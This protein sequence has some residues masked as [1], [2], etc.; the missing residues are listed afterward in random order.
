M[1]VIDHN[2]ASRANPVTRAQYVTVALLLCLM[3]F[4]ALASAKSF[5]QVGT[6]GGVLKAGEVSEQNQLGGASALA[7]NYTGAGGVPK[8]TVYAI[9][10]TKGFSPEQRVVRF[11]PDGAGLKFVEQ[12]E[13]I[14][15]SREK[16]REEKGNAPY[17]ICGPAV[18]NPS[19]GLTGNPNC[20]ASLEASKGT[21]G[22]AVDQSTGNVYV[23]TEPGTQAVGAP[24]IFEYTPNGSKVVA[25][26]GDRGPG[27]PDGKS[28]VE[29]PSQIHG[30]SGSGWLAVNDEGEVFVFDLQGGNNFYH[31]LMVFKPKVPGDYTEYVYAGQS[32]DIGA[33]FLN[34]T[35]FLEQPVLD[36]AGYVYVENSQVVEKY[37]R[38]APDAPICTFTFSKGQ[39][40]AMT[41]NPATGE[42]FFYSIV[43]PR[44]I[45]EL[46][47]CEDGAFKETGETEVA[48]E[49]AELTALTFDPARQL[50]AGG[51]PGVLY[52]AAPSAEP[53]TGKGQPGTSGLGYIF[54]QPVERPAAISNVAPL[55]VTSS[56]A[57]LS[58][59]VDP[60]GFATHYAFRYLS[61]TQYE[62][63]GETFG[64]AGE[65]PAGGASLPPAGGVQ[66]VE[67]SLTGLT[68][69]TTYVFQVVAS[70]NC[71]PS[72]PTKVCPVES[73]A[74]ELHTYP[75]EAP[76]LVD[77]RAY[78][79]VSPVD[80]H[81]G[82]VLPA[83]PGPD[84]G[85][86]TL[87]KPGAAAVRFPLQSRPDGGAVV[88]EGE[89]FGSGGAPNENEYFSRRTDAGWETTTLM[90]SRLQNR[91]ADEVA[92]GNGYTAFDPSL[93]VGWLRQNSV[94]LT[95]STLGEYG[96]L[97]R[98]PTAN[99]K[100]LTSALTASNASPTCPPNGDLSSLKLAYG[101]ADK[102]LSKVFFEANDALTA[103]STG[104]C[105]EWNLYE[106][107]AGA[108]RAV[109]VPPAGGASVPGAVLGSGQ[110]LKSG[111]GNIPSRIVTHAISDDG[112]RAF[113]T[114][115]DGRLYVRIDGASTVE[116][117]GPGNCS[118]STPLAARVCFLTA[119][120]DGS[121]VLLSNG[122]VY[123]VNGSGTAYE[124]GVDLTQGQGGFLG[125]AGQ[126]E[127]LNHL[128][129]FAKANLTGGEENDQGGVAEAG[130]S[131]LYSSVAG[132]THFVANLGF[133]DGELESQNW[134][135]ATVLRTAEASPAGRWL[136]FESNVQ[137]TGYDNVGP[138]DKRTNGVFQASCRQVYLYDS[139]SRSLT[140][141]SCN[142]SGARPVGRAFLPIYYAAETYV[143]QPRYLTDAGRLI[144]DSQD[145]LVPGDANE[146]V[147]DVYEYE[148][149]GVG[150]CSRPGYCLRLISS[151][152]GSTDSNFLT[153]D[154]TGDNVFFTTG[155]RLVG[156]DK[157]EQIDLY[158]ARVGGGFPEPQP[159]SECI[160]EACQQTSAAPVQPLPSSMS[161]PAEGDA[162]SGGH[163]S[164][165]KGKVKR[166]GRCVKK[167]KARKHKPD[168]KRHARKGGNH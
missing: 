116:V 89:P 28:E 147:E 57:S 152:R 117:P 107:A 134:L 96:N 157:D 73:A 10:H 114:G 25:R 133:P 155:N 102:Q 36:E 14:S 49:R 149:Q 41:V 122:Q 113:F 143:P 165:K 145:R 111:N 43:K 54:A 85:S 78:E 154:E 161:L 108:L 151:G 20:A 87:C 75:V 33:G 82:Q 1:D 77:G 2:W 58:A 164:C 34:E 11:S 6:F 50:S 95:A 59:L 146:G 47:A 156:A 101:S 81:G 125:I 162:K 131:N 9:A 144:F 61:L 126:S 69:E 72:E 12:W 132:D 24:M 13:V 52:G 64:G 103:D 29:T 8:G 16:E 26:F 46:S 44:R 27:S 22:I 104:T 148:P 3:L 99:P 110:L 76:G 67:A 137:L 35:N 106:A 56:S 135:A 127:D 39:I 92:R 167:H 31:R 32:A 94:P 138:C 15:A 37:D 79:L 130:K 97:Y 62:A 71:S 60:S 166:N 123:E 124:P 120:A 159:P 139:Q 98:Q 30:T 83:Y 48:P 17:E 65:I 129:F 84:R 4:P 42:P 109:N 142:P 88:Y 55:N 63:Q 140:C 45:H 66:R 150:G 163:R 153:M 121:S 53:D 40:R 128:Y 68:P 136:A 7:V 38:A 19:E 91:E 141:A 70:S 119:S 90:P 51:Q 86:C 118:A 160:G 23:G 105:G 21:L 168:G 100:A 115:A 93:T 112:S 5:E 80:K 18:A 158:V 74:A